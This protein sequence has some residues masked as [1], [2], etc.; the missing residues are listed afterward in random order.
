VDQPSYQFG[1]FSLAPGIRQL[2]SPSGPIPLT[3]KVYETLLLLVENR[4]KTL[5]KEELLRRIWPDTFVEE[6]NLAHNVSIL[7]RAL[8]DGENG[9]R[10]ILT[11]PKHGYRFVATVQEIA[12][13]VE[14]AAGSDALIVGVP[15]TAIMPATNPSAAK[16][17]AAPLR[18][19]RRT[20]RVAILVI[21]ALCIASAAAYFLWRRAASRA[22]AETN[23]IMLA[24]L[25][26]Q[27]LTGDAGQD[28]ISDGL[29]EE[30]I[31]QLGEMNPLRLG[32]IARTSSMAY[33]DAKKTVDQIGRELGVD[34]LLET[35]LRGSPDHLRF[36]AQLIRVRDQSH[37]WARDYDRDSR[38][39]VA[40][41]DN[42]SKAVVHE[43]RLQLAPEA[44]GRI[45]R[46]LVVKPDSYRSYL[47][48]RYCWNQRT[49]PGLEK[50]LALFQ[51]A[52]REDPANA[53]AYAGIA[54]S[55]N[56]LVFYGYSPGSA[57]IL[58]AANAAQKAIDLDDSLPDGHA[59]LGYS[60]L[61][62][63]WHWDKAETEFQR[64]ILLDDN[65]VSAHHWYALDLAV[66]GRKDEA[67]QQIRIAR[68]LDPVSPILNTAVA[69]VSYLVRDY[70]GAIRHASS[71]LD[72]HPDFA[73]ARTTL[74]LAY[75][76]KKM[77]SQAIVALSEASDL[78][79]GSNT[80]NLCFLAQALAVSGKRAEAEALLERINSIAKDGNYVGQ[81]GIA[82][83]YAGL[84]ENEKAIQSLYRA[85]DQ[86][87]GGMLW[88]R[89]DP[90]FDPVRSDPRFQEILRHQDASP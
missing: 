90:R 7:R 18:I 56:L 51:Q 86:N 16:Q 75:E 63:L 71:V 82:A 78:A 25:P 32:V 79:G 28:Y 59:A 15:P 74:G 3:P 87:D 17:A 9:S 47:Q 34:Y 4:G 29:T 83:I 21:A 88:L 80:V 84:G 22:S 24:V 6:N 31:A 48:G 19:G 20:G 5:A 64:A 33:K 27:N 76:Q 67:L 40:L 85:S 58:E 30:M 60:N 10:F 1:S 50:G 49:K 8:G 35:S 45:A 54:D 55:Y 41:E 46:A 68:Q 65:Y 57:S 73:V 36:T 38:D 39:L 44:Q 42:V 69:Y 26:V 53:R 37:M 89:V 77:Y 12:P 61:M 43:V 2:L 72:A 70:D 66:M 11:I 23:R 62:F 14:N 81:S 52:I 13:P